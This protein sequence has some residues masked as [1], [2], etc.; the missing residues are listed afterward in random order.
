V[1]IEHA[2]LNVIK[3][4]GLSLYTLYCGFAV[5]GKMVEYQNTNYSSQIFLTRPTQRVILK[6]PVP[7]Y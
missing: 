6:L 1:H 4:I 7:E 3:K 2:K 5:L